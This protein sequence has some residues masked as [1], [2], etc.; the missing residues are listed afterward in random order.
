MVYIWYIKQKCILFYISYIKF[1]GQFSLWCSIIKQYYKLPRLTLDLTLKV[2]Y[3]VTLRTI[4]RQKFM[5]IP[6]R[7]IHFWIWRT[8]TVLYCTVLTVVFRCKVFCWNMS[9]H[10]MGIC[11]LIMKED[12]TPRWIL[13]KDNWKKQYNLTL[14]NAAHFWWLSSMEG[15][16][17]DKTHKIYM[18]I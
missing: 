15:I 6:P 11:E 3:K 8:T 17:P 10:V 1:M 4:K 14:C 12:V 16:H 2:N 13:A 18:F 7:K 5:W 9:T